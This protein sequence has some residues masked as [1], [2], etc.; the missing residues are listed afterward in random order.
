MA[1]NR[2][3][4]TKNMITTGAADDFL[5]LTVTNS[6]SFNNPFLVITMNLEDLGGKG[7]TQAGRAGKLTKIVGA[8]RSE[9][10]DRDRFL[11]GNGERLGGW[12]RV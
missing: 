3:K 7:E 6:N 8:G 5:L 11:K 2:Q 1:A 9:R 4:D 12:G 10:R